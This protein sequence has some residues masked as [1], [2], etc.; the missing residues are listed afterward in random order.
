M[1]AYVNKQTNEALLESLSPVRFVWRNRKMYWRYRTG[2]CC[3]VA[4][5]LSNCIESIGG[6]DQVIFY[7]RKSDTLV[8]MC[9]RMRMRTGAYVRA[10][11][12]FDSFPPSAGVLGVGQ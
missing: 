2:Q 5:S 10:C 1:D 12:R 7:E 3:N 9:V 8:S 6:K 4:P 11:V